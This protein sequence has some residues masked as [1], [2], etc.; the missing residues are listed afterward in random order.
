MCSR[1]IGIYVHSGIKTSHII[2][3]STDTIESMRVQLHYPEEYLVFYNNQ[4]V[5]DKFTF[6]FFKIADGDHLYVVPYNKP[7]CDLFGPKKR[8]KI[9]NLRQNREDLENRIDHSYNM[10]KAR[11]FDLRLTRFEEKSYYLRKAGAFLN[12]FDDVSDYSEAIPSTIPS[13]NQGPSTDSLPVFWRSPE[14]A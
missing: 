13:Q 9:K 14:K 6:S 8:T 2:V 3:S 11:Y 12:I 10:E 4:L 1:V 7:H 5:L